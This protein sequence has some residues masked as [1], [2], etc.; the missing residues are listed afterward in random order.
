MIIQHRVNSINDLKVVPNEHG[1]EIDLR[2]SNGEIILSHDPFTE[3]DRFSDWLQHF[4]HRL[5]ILNVKE[6]GLEDRIIDQLNHLGISQYF[7]LDQPFPTLRK[8][9]KNGLFAAV[10]YSEYEPLPV[11]LPWK[12]NWV[13]ID[14]FSGSWDHLSSIRCNLDGM[15]PSLCLVS[16]ELQGRI[17][18]EEIL[19]IKKL[20]NDNSLK[21]DAVCT[22][23]PELWDK[24]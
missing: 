16:P 14:S 18:S 4:R 10:R 20:L 9:L 22:K 13:W 2:E 7:F 3:G 11:G 17:D 19:Y 5:I 15:D 1:V 12:F 6:D 23:F 24:A 21:L 8:S